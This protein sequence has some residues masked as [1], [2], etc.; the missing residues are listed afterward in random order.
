VSSKSL[1]STRPTR[2]SGVLES[3]LA[4]LR[5]RKANSLIPAALRQG[6]ILDV[7]CGSYPYFL[8][9]TSF[10]EKFAID[11]NRP[12]APLPDVRWH[13]LDLN[14][15]PNLPFA[16][17]YFSA[18]TLLAVA[19]HLDPSNLARLFKEIHRTLQPG[20]MVVITTPAAWS[21]GVLR[22]MAR[23]HLVSPEEIAEHVFAY[24]TPLLGWYFGM[25]GF[26]MDKLRFGYFELKLNIW[27]TAV[28]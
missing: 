16:D 20:G 10:R 24:T 3:A 12:D 1:T 2:G 7:G 17:A 11:Q 14:A 6:R 19:E 5:A 22:V 28:R 26:S 4:R 9:H 13:A 21:D 8:A 27:A 23:L 15:E 25:A 18:I